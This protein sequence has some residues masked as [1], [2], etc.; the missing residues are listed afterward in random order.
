MPTD[1]DEHPAPFRCARHETQLRSRVTHGET[2]TT[3]E[4]WCPDCRKEREADQ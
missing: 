3:F 1:T 2:G 4:L